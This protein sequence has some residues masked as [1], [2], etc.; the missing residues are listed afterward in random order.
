MSVAYF[1]CFSGAGGDMIVASL[2][3]AG[4][5]AARLRRRLESLPVGGYTLT[6]EKV[7]KQGFAATRFVVDLDRAAPQPH[8]HLKDVLAIIRGAGD[9]SEGVK[10]RAGRVF[11]RLAAAEAAVHGIT[12]D[13]VHFH[14]VG[15]VDAILDVVGA[16][17]A[18][19]L[20]GVDRV[21]CSALPTGSGTVRC[22]HGEL[23]VP[24]PATAELLKGVPLAACEETGEL[25][26]PTGAALLTT[27]ADSFGPLPSITVRAVGYGAGT[28]EGASR[29]NLLRV[30]VGDAGDAGES[31][32][33]AVLETNLDDTTPQTAAYC[34]ERLLAEGAL[35]VYSL[36]IQMKKSRSGVLLTVLCE[37]HRVPAMERILFAETPTFGVRRHSVRRTKLR[38]R[39]EAV[40]TP[41]G[42]IRVKVGQRADALTATPEFEDCKT[43]AL[44]A[45][46]SLA[47]VITA[48]K[49]AWER[50]RQA[51]GG[52]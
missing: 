7:T 45:G 37:C 19:E 41:Y 14:E 35:D 6:I 9:L 22:A 13:R 50:S 30:L 20:L 21:A 44:A 48:A 49:A 23:P 52:T 1:D 27:L 26:T 38:R 39:V 34:M 42:T 24:G 4:A 29:P 11:E 28:R 15:A 46:V 2:I 40:T 33:I 10:G 3:D 18:L 12:I 36:P 32:E 51:L 5:D 17:T 43:A 47:T 25:T 16:V 31:D 8:R